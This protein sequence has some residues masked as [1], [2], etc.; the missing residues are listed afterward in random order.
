MRPAEPALLDRVAALCRDG[1]AA[2]ERFDRDVRRRAWHP[3][4]P[5]DYDR[6]LAHLLPHR[7]PG[8][9]LLEMGSATGVVA[10]MADLL[11][12]EAYGIEIDGD[13]VAVARSL[14]ERHG[15]G[16]RFATGSFVPEG[17]VWRSG[18]GDDRL[19]TIEVGEPAY[20]EL[21]LELRDFDV[22]FAYPWHGEAPLLRDIVRRCGAPDVTLLLYGEPRRPTPGW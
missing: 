12:F 11:G 3:F 17:Y 14:A 7:A 10:I 4:M 8:R 16:A 1:R 6:A 19:G 21:G 18:T 20:E 15:S 13:L 22:V 5:A 2:W 9:R